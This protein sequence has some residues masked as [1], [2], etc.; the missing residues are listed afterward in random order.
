MD[1]TRLEAIG[2][3]ALR[4]LVGYGMAKHGWEKINGDMIG[5][6]QGVVADKL[7][8]PVPMLFAWAA[9]LS[10]FGGG[11]MLMA[12]LLTRLGAFLILC[13]VGTAFFVFHAADP[14][15]VKEL[16]FVYGAAAISLI[17]TG[18]GPISLDAKFG[19]KRA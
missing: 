12:G 13:V 7:G 19:R 8:F 9:A 5:F 14:W 18:G 4:L 6:A 1:K 11:L 16:A 10:E 2:L 15:N 3:L 17:L